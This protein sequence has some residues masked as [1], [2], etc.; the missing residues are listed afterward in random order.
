[1]IRIVVTTAI[2]AAGS[3]GCGAD[4][5]A[6][7]A[8][9]AVERVEVESGR[10]P[11]SI[12]GVGDALVGI[13]ANSG[14]DRVLHPDHAVVSSVDFGRSWT[15]V[16]LPGVATDESLFL[17]GPFDLGD[18][19]AVTARRYSL[20]EGGPPEAPFANGPLW[21]WTTEAGRHWRGGEL[22]AD[23]PVVVNASVVRVGDRIFT[24][25]SSGESFFVYSSRDGGATWDRTEVDGLTFDATRE[26]LPEYASLESMWRRGDEL[27]GS[28]GVY[29]PLI[30][31]SDDGAKWSTEACT[32]DECVAPRIAGDLWIRSWSRQEWSLDGGASWH[33][34]PDIEGD[35][36]MIRSAV[37]LAAGGWF[38]TGAR[39]DQDNEERIIAELI[40]SDDGRAWER[41]VAVLC[42]DDKVTFGGETSDPV[43]IGDL[44]IVTAT[45]FPS[46]GNQSVSDAYALR[47]DGRTLQTV[48]GA[49][50]SGRGLGQPV[51]LGDQVVVPV[52]DRDGIVAFEVITVTS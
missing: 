44:W 28:L 20:V 4:S 46:T 41:V 6:R 43:E 37:A 15:P 18:V 3:A 13:A 10:V 2:I 19:V 33:R 45:C 16:D 50:V 9:F 8:V 7:P 35:S 47:A 51:A 40:R 36:V 34:V 25:L 42:P 30:V 31:S 49:E 24:G 23:G 39:G 32:Q 1:M 22:Q 5:A 48:P 17:D 12:V 52:S 26:P 29:Q 38:A 11:G 27:V 14:E 21:V